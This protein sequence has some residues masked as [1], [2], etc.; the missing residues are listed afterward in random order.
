MVQLPGLWAPGVE[1]VGS[2]LTQPLGGGVGSHPTSRERLEPGRYTAI[3][4]V[5]S[6]QYTLQYIQCS[7]YSIHCAQYKVCNAAYTVISLQ[8]TL[9]YTQ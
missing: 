8:Y 9:Q 5:T 6:I 2:R 3:Y 7:V 4:T 1:V